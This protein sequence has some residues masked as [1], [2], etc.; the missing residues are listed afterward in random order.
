[1]FGRLKFRISYFFLHLLKDQK[2]LFGVGFL[3]GM[4]LAVLLHKDEPND[5]DLA[6]YSY[7]FAYEK[8][9]YS[10]G[11]YS[12]NID[13]D[14]NRYKDKN[15]TDI[16]APVKDYTEA[17]F[18]YDTVKVLCLVFPGTRDGAATVNRTWGQHCNHMRFYHQTL[19]D[20]TIPIRK[21]AS[22]SSFGLLCSSLLEVTDIDYD[23]VVVA[24]EDTFVLP[25]NLRYYVSP[26][27]SSDPHY[28]GHAM[29]FWNVVYNWQ[30]A[31]Y[32]LSRG[33]VDK[34][35]Y[36]F[37]TKEGCESGGKYWKNGDWYLGKH[38]HQLGINPVDTRDEEGKG[39][40]NGY[41]FKKLLFPGAV[42]GFERYW[43]DSLYLS[44]DGPRCC[45]NNAVSFHG[46][47]SNSK[48]Y[49]LEYLFYHLRPFYKG[50]VHGN[51]AA[52][53]PLQSPHLSWEERWKEEEL[54]KV[55][56]SLLT[57][58]ADMTG[59]HLNSFKKV[60]EELQRVS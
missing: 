49:Q 9:L 3:L 24:T 51:K 17:G 50:G 25:E 26:L 58:P 30:D 12:T 15:G 43:K 36:K 59:K 22:G 52:P 20:P 14:L 38:L 11:L 48:M 44:E 8:W 33:A 13:P 40:F 41:S 10:K 55:F 6:K 37:N 42:S 46:I 34:L 35:L 39:R 45:S 54:M 21:L 7:D 18:L 47:L 56:D 57:T 5:P 27:N 23:W 4:L 60:K 2:S 16:E 28:L 32:T 29:R 31:A 1:M 19:K 53:A